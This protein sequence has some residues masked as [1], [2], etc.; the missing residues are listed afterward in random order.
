MS[1]YLDTHHKDILI[2]VTDYLFD[3]GHRISKPMMDDTANFVEMYARSWYEQGKMAQRMKDL[4]KL[5]FHTGIP[6]EVLEG[7]LRSKD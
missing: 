1:N 3:K 4:K 5:S 2:Q 6:T 7:Y